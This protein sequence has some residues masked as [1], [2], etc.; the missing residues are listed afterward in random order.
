MRSEDHGCAGAKF[1]SVLGFDGALFI[2][3]GEI[4]RLVST[5]A[6]GGSLGRNLYPMQ[7]VMSTIRA[8]RYLQFRGRIRKSSA[9]GPATIRDLISTV[10][11]G[12]RRRRGRNKN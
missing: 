5:A 1:Q 2:R 6:D 11:A 10:I 12:A 4:R 9:L 7:L 3:H 8:R